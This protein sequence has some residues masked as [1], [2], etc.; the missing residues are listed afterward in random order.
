MHHHK[1]GVGHGNKHHGHGGRGGRVG[2]GGHGQLGGHP[3]GIFKAKGHKEKP[4]RHAYDS[5]QGDFGRGHKKVLDIHRRKQ[6]RFM[7][8]DGQHSQGRAGLKAYVNRDKC[9]LCG[10]CMK[11]CPTEA[12]VENEESI[13]IDVD[14]CIGCGHCVERCK[15]GALFLIEGK[16]EQKEA[17]IN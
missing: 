13:R 10:K 2:R 9:V 1:G 11:V 17:V 5:E 7:G 6:Q 12:I 14:Q 15:K 16:E 4:G 3:R 8:T